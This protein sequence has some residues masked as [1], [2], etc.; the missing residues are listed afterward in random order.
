MY[1]LMHKLSVHRNAILENEV[2]VVRVMLRT[3]CWRGGGGYSADFD[4]PSIS[5]MLTNLPTIS[6]RLI[7]KCR[8][9]RRKLCFWPTRLGTVGVSSHPLPPPLAQYASWGGRNEIA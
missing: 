9:F 4:L 1:E 7:E 8:F 3:F 5:I 6:N 2:W